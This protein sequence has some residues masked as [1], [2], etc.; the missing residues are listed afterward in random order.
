MLKA[1]IFEKEG[2]TCSEKNIAT[3]FFFVLWRVT[4]LKGRFVRVQQVVRQ[5]SRSFLIIS[6]TPERL[7][8]TQIFEKKAIFPMKKIMW[9]T[10]SR[11]IECDKH[12]R[13][14]CKGPQAVPTITV[15]S[16][17]AFFQ[18]LSGCWKHK[19]L[20]KK[21]I[22]QVKKLLWPIFSFII[23]C[24]KAQGTVSKGPKGVLTITVESMRAF[25]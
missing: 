24:H 2:N 20:K 3:C 6:G 1:Q 19:F 11:I 8:Q 18:D 5:Y 9:P 23:E 4:N 17:R 15:E 21:A 13:T 25:F 22:F 10:F 7:L 14:I 12:Q 16:M